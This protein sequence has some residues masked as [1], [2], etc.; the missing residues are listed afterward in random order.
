MSKVIDPDLLDEPEHD[1]DEHEDLCDICRTPI[2]DDGCACGKYDPI[3]DD[4]KEV[5]AAEPK[6]KDA[7]TKKLITGVELL[8]MKFPEMKIHNKNFLPLA[9]G[10]L[11]MISGAGGVGKGFVSLQSVIRYLIDNKDATA[12]LWYVEDPLRVLKTRLMLFKVDSSVLKRLYFLEADPSEE[13]DWQDRIGKFDIVVIDPLVYFFDEEEN[14]NSEAKVF[15]RK[16]NKTCIDANN[17]IIIVHHHNKA[18]STRGASAFTDNSRLVYELTL[19]KD[20]DAPAKAVDVKVKKDNF[21]VCKKEISYIVPQKMT[22][23]ETV[24]ETF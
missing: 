7:K 12:L 10:V 20:D 5:K 15:M 19:R 2:N 18:G 23:A 4:K 11:T 13:K 21:N 24:E 1:A 22:D 16:L 6:S 8:K 9:D 3:E 14:N 17:I